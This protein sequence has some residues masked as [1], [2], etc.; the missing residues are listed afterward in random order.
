MEIVILVHNIF[1]QHFLG[2]LHDLNIIT[3][4]PTLQ[5]L[6]YGFPY[7]FKIFKQYLEHQNVTCTKIRNK[8]KETKRLYGVEIYI[9]LDYMKDNKSAHFSS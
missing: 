3:H 1:S 7:Y 2:S 6:H 4:H 8:Q 9:V 5:R